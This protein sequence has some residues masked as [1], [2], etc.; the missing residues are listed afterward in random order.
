MIPGDIYMPY[1]SIDQTD[2]EN[3]I[4]IEDSVFCPAFETT[5]IN[6]IY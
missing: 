1:I 2:P 3:E 6:I 5:E 4:E